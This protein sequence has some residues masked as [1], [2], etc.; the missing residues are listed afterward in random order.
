MFAKQP[1][2]RSIRHYQKNLQKMAKLFLACGSRS[3][4]RCWYAVAGISQAKHF[5]AC[6]LP[7][8]FFVITDVQAILL[9]VCLDKNVTTS[10]IQ[11]G[12]IF[13]DAFCERCL[14]LCFVARKPVVALETNV[15]AA[16]WGILNG[17]GRGH[18]E[19]YHATVKVV[20]IT[21]PCVYLATVSP[22]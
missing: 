19:C 10:C 21:Y 7:A 13:R 6:W 9:V 15:K 14:R 17:P 1:R 2:R 8:N 22:R 20:Y 16:K 18:G 4:L 3:R 11:I 5:G 12:F